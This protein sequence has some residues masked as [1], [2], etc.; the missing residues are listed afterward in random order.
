MTVILVK[1]NN[2][3]ILPNEGLQLLMLAMHFGIDQ[4]VIYDQGHICEIDLQ[5]GHNVI[6]K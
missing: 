2:V 3:T 4:V 1:V 6:M 5:S